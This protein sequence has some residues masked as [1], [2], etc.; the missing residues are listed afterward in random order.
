MLIEAVVEDKGALWTE[1]CISWIS[2]D[3]VSYKGMRLQVVDIAFLPC[4]VVPSG[5]EYRFGRH[6]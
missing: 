6:F 1:G 3:I 5:A 4:V 2:S